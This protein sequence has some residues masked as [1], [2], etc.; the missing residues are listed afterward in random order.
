MEEFASVRL[1]RQEVCRG[2]L[3][4]GLVGIDVQK[5]SFLDINGGHVSQM[6]F[7]S[8]IRY[9]YTQDPNC[10]LQYT[11][12][13]WGGVNPQ[14]EIEVNFYVESD[15]MPSFSERI[16]EPDGR[17]GEELVPLDEEERVVTRHIHSRVLFSY[18][19]AVA[20]KHWLEEKIDSLE[21]EES[22]S[23]NPDDPGF[24]VQ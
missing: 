11:H 9:E 14:G 10:R 18:E 2:P 17:Y 12:G 21:M 8:R 23:Y 3:L 6:K 1:F 4:E 19:T 13:V 15:K 16:V 5:Q 24:E 20:L 22:S 7:P